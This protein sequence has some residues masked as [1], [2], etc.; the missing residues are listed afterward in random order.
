MVSL[1]ES[2]PTQPFV[3]ASPVRR[4]RSATFFIGVAAALGALLTAA[5][6]FTV[7]LGLTPFTPDAQTTLLLIAV[8][9][10]F[11]MLLFGLIVLE[12]LRIYKSRKGQRAASRLHV[13]IIAMFS[14]VAAIPAILVAVIASVT[15]E[16]GLDRWFELRTKVIVYSSLSIADAYVQ[17]NARSLSLER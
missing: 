8:N 3:A 10:A 16:L 9:F 13:R 11:I 5:V 17:Q 15:L 7:L 4:G 1:S 12:G 14:L 2:S 6:S